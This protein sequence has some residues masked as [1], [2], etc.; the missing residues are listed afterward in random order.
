M[1]G[2]GKRRRTAEIY[3]KLDLEVSDQK[4]GSPVMNGICRGW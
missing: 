4:D 3:E 1:L 2:G